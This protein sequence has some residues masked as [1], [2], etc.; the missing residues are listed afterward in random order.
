MK[1][2]V[3]G[4][5]G[6]LG[7]H[8]VRRLLADGATVTA[9][10]R[11]FSDSAG[12]RH[13]RLQTQTGD[14]LDAAALRGAVRGVD[15]VYHLISTT[16]PQTSNQDPAFDVSSNVIGTLRL[17]DLCVQEGVRRV[18]FV[19]SGGTIYGV[20][21]IIPIPEDHPT[22]PTSSYG[23]G[24]LAIEKYLALYRQLHGLD[25]RIAR[26]ANPYGEGQLPNRAQ[27]AVSVFL[28]SALQRLPIRIW[29]DGSVVRD[30]VYVADAIEGLMA[31]A[32][33]QGPERIFN[34]G[35]GRGLS[36][37]ELLSA[38]KDLL[39]EPQIVE[40]LP[41]RPFDVPRVVLDIKRAQT[42]LNWQPSTPFAD[43]LSRVLTWLQN[44]QANGART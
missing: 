42:L 27:G 38:I 34:I 9:F 41:A 6:F 44:T 39:G 26:L 36:L 2:L 7:T 22:E 18:L 17:L 21:S 16:L 43:G 37:L 5:G 3:L 40:F 10:D 14:F 8:L 24:K 29:G 19:S 13:A 33:Y 28:N 25:Y 23:I 4:G 32:A 15:S 35:A 31:V 20:P 11:A 1:C 30:Y 12:L